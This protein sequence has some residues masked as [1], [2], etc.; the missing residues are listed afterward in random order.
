MYLKCQTESINRTTV[1]KQRSFIFK[2]IK[3]ATG[4]CQTS[5]SKLRYFHGSRKFRSERNS[6]LSLKKL[7]KL[8]LFIN[9]QLKLPLGIEMIIS[10]LYKKWFHLCYSDIGYYSHNL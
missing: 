10:M 9:L 6:I 7:L 8:A 2:S 1:V 4:F 3:I 5:K